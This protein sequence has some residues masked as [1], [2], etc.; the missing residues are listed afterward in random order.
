MVVCERVV[1]RFMS[2]TVLSSKGA[3]S[4]LA[5]WVIA[6][7]LNAGDII[8]VAIRSRSVTLRSVDRLQ[9]I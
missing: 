5:A 6:F 7:A 1:P 9:L 2:G 8:D 4:L 3:V